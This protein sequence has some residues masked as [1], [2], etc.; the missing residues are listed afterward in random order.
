MAWS[1]WSRCPLLALSLGF[2][3][4]PGSP[5]EAP[6]TPAKD[7]AR[8]WEHRGSVLSIAFAPDGRWF[9]TAGAA[10]GRS[11]VFWDTETGKRRLAIEG[12]GLVYSVAL[13]PD[14]KRLATAGIVGIEEGKPRG[15]AAVWDTATGKELFPLSRYS[16]GVRPCI[17]FSP[18]GKLLATGTLSG[19]EEEA[20]GAVQLWD[21]ATG[22]AG[23]LLIGP[24]E[25]FSQLAFSPDGKL[26]AAASF[27]EETF[28]V[29]W[30]VG[31][32]KRRAVLKSPK[33][34]TVIR[35]IAFSADSRQL[36]WA[37]GNEVN[38]NAELF[39]WDVVRETKIARL[40]VR[41]LMAGVIF[42]PDGKTLISVEMSG[43]FRT[44]E[45]STLKKM[46]EKQVEFTTA[47]MVLAAALAPNG[48]TLVL[49]SGNS[50]VFAPPDSRHGEVRLFDLATG[51]GWLAPERE[52]RRAKEEAEN[53]A[54]QTARA[55][56]LARQEAELR[57]ETERLSP[58][59]R[60]R[61][62]KTEAVERRLL[63]SLHLNQAHQAIEL[64]QL[65]V[66]QKLLQDYRPRPG[67]EDLRSFEWHYLWRRCQ[68]QVLEM[69]LLEKALPSWE[70]SG[71]CFSPDGKTLAVPTTDHLI[72]LWDT[73]TGKLRTTLGGGSGNARHLIFSPDGKYLATAGGKE[74]KGLVSFPP[75]EEPDDPS[76]REALLWEV[77]TG[78]RLARLEGSGKAVASVAFSPDAK[79]VALGDLAG[80]VRVWEVPSGRLKTRVRLRFDSASALAFAPDGELLA[81]GSER[82][83]LSVW[84]LASGD[85]QVLSDTRD[86]KLITSI[87]FSPDGRSLYSTEGDW[88]DN[89]AAKRWQTAP[90]GKGGLT[91]EWKKVS[92]LALAPDG[93][94][95][96]LSGWGDVVIWDVNAER[97]LARVMGDRLGSLACFS[98]ESNTVLVNAQ[99]APEGP[100]HLALYDAGN[101]ER[102]GTVD[103]RFT[104]LS[105]SGIHLGSGGNVVAFVVAD[106][107]DAVDHQVL[108]LLRVTLEHTPEVRSYPGAFRGIPSLEFTSDSRRLAV[109]DG[110]SGF[111][112]EL[113]TGK[114]R[115]L[116]E[117][118]SLPVGTVRFSKDDGVLLARD[119]GWVRFFDPVT[120]RE[121]ASVKGESVIG[122]DGQ[123]VFLAEEDR[124]ISLYATKD[125]RKVGSLGRGRN[126][127][128]LDDVYL[129]RK[130]VQDS[131]G[132]RWV[133]GF[134]EVLW[135]LPSKK[136]VRAWER[137]A[138]S[139]VQFGF[140]PDDQTLVTSDGRGTVTVWDLPGVKERLVLATAWAPGGVSAFS[141]DNR[142]AALEQADRT[143][144]LLDLKTGER[145]ARLKGL[146]AP[147]TRIAFS[148]DG[149]C[150]VSG[151]QDGT[152]RC[153]CPVSGVQR[154]C[155]PGHTGALTS[156]AFSPDG[157]LLAT[158]SIDGTVRLWSTH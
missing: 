86:K 84:R 70:S 137:G 106:K 13:S 25:G 2:L 28:V 64:G 143:I 10:K 6:A 149:K 120:A 93:N 151:S 109:S 128:E 157:S 47:N 61:F 90:G 79:S 91:H 37:S 21:A 129:L 63:Y 20:V 71:P 74:R 89:Y 110:K 83:A 7:A 26:L 130:A 55:R 22:K 116:F 153:W 17:A 80:A 135:D 150:L 92:R 152:I 32:R 115:K 108:R 94:R 9:V 78:K 96:A 54:Q 12:A 42:H 62:A 11:V 114:Q 82:G 75:K 59:M 58:A 142:T 118:N 76:V 117:S 154:L 60:A 66:A 4:I 126:V 8:I 50:D 73:T 44:W 133:V 16:E 158:G 38:G 56:E 136:A 35:S 141:P 43:S 27:G 65:A 121:R 122:S 67:E 33:T 51:K 111:L 19:K 23:D 99:G 29:L 147:V 144:L 81:V 107:Q 104:C 69:E 87:Q 68:F 34:W 105:P 48:K 14:G 36:A 95:L 1:F 148:P 39:L 112:W 40:P 88:P 125:G 85:E 77:G 46:A 156:L 132:G 53:E 124:T 139:P 145:L 98:P 15:R 138:V 102:V 103:N 113:Q 24:S 131:P 45:R 127:A 57:R 134:E 31:S 49:G 41:T 146:S 30:D 18:D 52:A 155:L 123:I 97:A 101:G 5:A 140:T 100:S 119:P 3:S 72:T